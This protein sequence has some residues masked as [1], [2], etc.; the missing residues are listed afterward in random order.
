VFIR[1][2]VFLLEHRHFGAC[3]KFSQNNGR[4]ALRESAWLGTLVKD[5]RDVAAAVLCSEGLGVPEI[6]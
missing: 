1:G 5:V 3:T 2:K 4:P 6:S